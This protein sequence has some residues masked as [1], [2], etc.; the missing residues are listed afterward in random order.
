MDLALHAA[1]PKI[2][3][4]Y[5]YY[6]DRYAT[7]HQEVY[8]DNSACGSWVDWYGQVVCDLDTLT[9]LVDFDTIDPSEEHL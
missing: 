4:Y 1:A 2:E 3:A 9:R 5:Q 8:S 7:K 6:N